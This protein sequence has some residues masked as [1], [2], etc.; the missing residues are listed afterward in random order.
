VLILNRDLQ[1]PQAFHLNKDQKRGQFV[2]VTSR[3]VAGVFFFT[4]T[5]TQPGPSYVLDKPKRQG[6]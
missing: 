5:H 4:N 3:K 1:R 6:K 2:K